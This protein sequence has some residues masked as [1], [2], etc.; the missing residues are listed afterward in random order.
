MCIHPECM[1]WAMDRPA[2]R[3]RPHAEDKCAIPLEVHIRSERRRLEAMRAEIP[4]LRAEMELLRAEHASMTERW[5][6]RARVQVAQRIDELATRVA[7]LASDG[8][9]AEFERRVA[10]YAMVR[11][12]KAT[13]PVAKRRR[14]VNGAVVAASGAASELVAEYLCEVQ[15]EPPRMVVDHRDS[16]PKCARDM[17]LIAT[18][19]LMTCPACGYAM[20]Y[21]DATTS[22]VSYGDE[23]QFASFSYKRLNH[24]NEWLQQVQAKETFEIKQHIVDA[25]ME[26]LYRQR[27]RL[28]AITTQRVREVLKKLKLKKTYEHVG[29]ITMR[30][31]GLPPPRLTAEMEEFCRLCF[32]AAQPAFEKHCPADRTNFLSYSYIC[33]RILQ[34]LGYE[35][36]LDALSLLKGKDKLARQNEIFELMCRELDWEYIPEI[37]C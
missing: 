12:S 31:T 8:H 6:T 14:L 18:K 5:Q 29:Q 17:L 24:F 19:S 20:A 13:A 9:I 25:V 7:T 21:I 23:V 30:I 10:P 16:C 36:L 28:S 32:I 26:E 4:V 22:L 27:V 33:Y 35:D 37:G 2:R 3:E 11:G 34:L 1:E 15:G